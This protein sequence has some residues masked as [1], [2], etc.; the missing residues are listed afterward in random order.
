MTGPNES[1]R[2]GGQ[3]AQNYL[4]DMGG[5]ATGAAEEDETGHWGIDGWIRMIHNLIDLQIRTAATVVQAAMAGPAWL[6]PTDR[7]PLDSEE[8]PVAPTDYPR[9]F[10][11]VKPFVRV[12]HQDI[13]IPNTAIRFVPAI[14]GPGATKFQIDLIDNDFIGANYSGEVA[15]VPV[16]SAQTPPREPETISVTVGL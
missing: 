5:I 10:R 12:G 6:R 16:D 14:L 2:L 11:I 7:E 9:Y 13:V 4:S 15:L 1:F 3:F 8:I